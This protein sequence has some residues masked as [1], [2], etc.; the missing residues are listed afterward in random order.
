MNEHERPKNTSQSKQREISL[1]W[2]ITSEG[3]DQSDENGGEIISGTRKK[4]KCRKKIQNNE[5]PGYCDQPE[6][7]RENWGTN[8]TFFH[9]FEQLGFSVNKF[10]NESVKQENESENPQNSFIV[11]EEIQKI[12]L[13]VVVI[14]EGERQNVENIAFH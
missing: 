9:Q 12:V 11:V 2:V 4:R 14:D 13:Q 3:N 5:K 1:H 10:R 8:A 7:N 6:R